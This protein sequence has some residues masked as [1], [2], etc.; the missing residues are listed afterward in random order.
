MK[1]LPLHTVAV[2]QRKVFL[3]V[4]IS[5]ISVVLKRIS[6]M[7]WRTN[8]KT[9]ALLLILCSTIYCTEGEDACFVCNGAVDG[10]DTHVMYRRILYPTHTG[11]CHREWEHALHGDQLDAL[12]FKVEP[13]GALFQGDSKFLNPTFQKSH[14][15]SDRWLWVGL[16]I[17]MAIVSGG[18]SA[19]LAIVSHHSA[20]I[21]FVVGFLLPGIGILIFIVLPKRSGRFELRGTKIATTFDVVNCLK[22]NYPNH[23]AA[24][25]CIRCGVLLTPLSESEVSKV[26][27]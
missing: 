12:V 13:R 1:R 21:A 20:L 22:C 6:K 26:K 10:T 24:E 3:V 23:P 2:L 4:E 19:A 16:G 27:K 7:V 5:R 17:L 9:I 11:N 14:P 18:F 25:D 8:L 15:M